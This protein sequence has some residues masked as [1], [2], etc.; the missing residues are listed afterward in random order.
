MELHID[1]LFLSNFRNYE[2]YELSDIGGMTI[3]I[4]P[5]AVGKTNILEA[6]D[7]LTAGVSFRHP[8]ISQLI[9]EGADAARIGMDVTDG[10]RDIST[11]LKLEAGKKR[12]TVNGKAKQA[13]DVKGILP[14]VSFV[15]DDL[16]MAK[17]A[18]SIRRGALDDLGSQLSKNYH[19]L[20][21]DFEKAL[22]YKNRLLKEEAPSQ[23]IEAM[24]ETFA[25]CATQLFCY[26]TALFARMVPLVGEHYQAISKSD[27]QFSAVYVPSWDRLAGEPA[28]QGEYSREEASSLMS[29]AL[30]AWSAEESSRH[31][32]LV[33]PHNDQIIFYIS[34]RNTSDFA[35]QGQQRSIVL[36]WKL[37]EVDMVR[38]TIGSNPVL[39]LDD[40]MSELDVSRRS[41]LVKQ[42]GG[43]IQTFITATDLSYFDGDLLDRSRIVELGG[44]R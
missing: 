1:S 18:S 21:R 6:I 11:V 4:G 31:R 30:S 27:D 34:G 16:N 14:A 24:N 41:M 36:A 8:Q 12:Y 17:G 2:T 43:D 39:L 44:N 9:R 28:E 10:N 33:G 37:S 7:L 35:S 5:N 23:L 26:R 3:F 32:S 29:R 19:V 38:Q 42:V 25:L 13:A 20:R 40:V 15:P 22:R